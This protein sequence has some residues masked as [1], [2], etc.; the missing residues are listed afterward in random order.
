MLVE[1]T[2]GYFA[3]VDDEDFDYINQF[4]W[5]VVITKNNKYAAGNIKGK[6]VQMHRLILNASKNKFVD[7][8]NMNGL[9]N[10][11]NNLRLCNRSQN[12]MNTLK[13][14]NS[15]SSKYKGIHK[16]SSKKN[17]WR[18]QIRLNGKIYHLGCFKTKKEAALAYNKAAKKLFKEYANL[19]KGL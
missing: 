3:I 10:R 5:H 8:K 11:K 6:T 9:D 19:N 17:P 14:C 12:R 7:H 1:L 13:P 18:S 2:K 4:S 16:C 15:K